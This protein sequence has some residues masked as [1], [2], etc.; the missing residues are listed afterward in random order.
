MYLV[1]YDRDRECFNPCLLAYA[2]GCTWF[3]G[4]LS[5][6]RECFN[7]C[8]LTYLV[9]LLLLSCPWC[10]DTLPPPRYRE[11]TVSTRAYW[12]ILLEILCFLAHYGREGSV[13]THAY[14]LILLDILGVL[15]H[16]HLLRTEKRVFQPMLI[17]LSC[18]FII[19][20]KGEFQ[21]TLIGLT[22]WIYLFSC[23]DFFGQLDFTKSCGR[24][25]L[26]LCG[27]AGYGSGN[28]WLVV[29]DPHTDPGSN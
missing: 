29:V 8:L 17:G 27:Y 26:T 16:Y 10:V 20:E 24:I 14:W 12:L 15:V 2:V 4:S 28:S 3:L 23:L 1:H 6:R 22:C 11:G 21:S 19:T 9:V 25:V 7:P 18:W 13:S 5:Q